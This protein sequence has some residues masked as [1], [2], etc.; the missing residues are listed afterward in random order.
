MKSVMSLI[1]LL[2]LGVCASASA[3]DSPFQLQTVAERQAIEQ[4][5]TGDYPRALDQRL[6]AQY[7]AL[8]TS[9]GK[10]TFAGRTLEGPAAIEK[11]F[12]TAG[13]APA[14]AASAPARN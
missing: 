1:A 10:L 5:L 14:P 11:F 2:M 3:A 7:A 6:W 9:D 8:F 4:M 13:S 12:L